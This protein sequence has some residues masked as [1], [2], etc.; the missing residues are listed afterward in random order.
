MIP[1]N[2]PR[3]EKRTVTIGKYIIFMT[4]GRCPDGGDCVL[5]NCPLRM[6]DDDN[7]AANNIMY[8]EIPCL[9]KSRGEC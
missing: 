1:I 9:Y 5:I 3:R 2:C 4:L 7:N 6:D 8:K